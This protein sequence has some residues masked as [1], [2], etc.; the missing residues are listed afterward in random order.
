MQ[1]TWKDKRT[2]TWILE[3][4]GKDLHLRS[5][6]MMGKNKYFGHIVRRGGG[7]E[8]QNTSGCSG[9]KM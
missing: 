5:G 8:K 3:K 9:G 1:T 2:N 6:I 7:I 4:I